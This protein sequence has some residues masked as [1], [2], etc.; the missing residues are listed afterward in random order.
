MTNRFNGKVVVI[1]SG[2]DGIGLATARSFVAEGAHVYITGRRQQRLDESMADIGRGAVGICGDVTNPAD[3]DRLYARIRRDHGR[4]DVVFANA[5]ISGSAPM[6]GIGE[7][8]V[9][10]LFVTNVKS[11]VFT[12]QKALPL[13]STGSTI[14]LTGS[15]AG[16]KGFANS[17]ARTWTADL[18]EHGIRVN[19]ISPGMVLKPAMPACLHDNT[20]AGPWGQQATPFDR[21]ARTDEIAKAVLSLASN[22]SSFIGDGEPRVDG[23]F[24]AV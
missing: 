9:D 21:L 16:N 2:T 8:H 7:D 18:K 10:R 23:G 17:L 15:G 22:E 6:G 3:L 24:V 19:V 11:V 13:M 12:V 14:V 4:V 5:G 20:G 1:T